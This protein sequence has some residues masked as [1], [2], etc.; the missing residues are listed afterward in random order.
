MLPTRAFE[1]GVFVAYANRCAR[2]NDL[3]YVGLSCVV[4][5][6][7]VDLARAQ[8]HETLIFAEL[9]HDLMA[10]WRR[11]NTYLAD[12]IPAHYSALTDTTDNPR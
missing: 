2:E 8:Q 3:D 4:G 9:E 6:N 7:G 11:V 10:Q 12:R 5:P 1:N